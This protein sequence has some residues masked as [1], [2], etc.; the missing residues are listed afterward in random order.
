MKLLIADDQNSV[1]LFLNQMLSYEELGITEV[2]HARNGQ[3]AL[4]VIR[5]EW[6]EI[7]LL[8]IRMPVMDGLTLLEKISTM[9]FEHRVLI[10]SA[11]NEFEYA[12]KCIV[13]GVKEYLL[14]P[15]DI[16]EVKEILKKNIQELKELRL[17][18]WTAAL[19]DYLDSGKMDQEKI[20]MGFGKKGFGVVVQKSGDAELTIV[21]EQERLLLTVHADD[22]VFHFIETGSEAMWETFYERHADAQRESSVGFSQ[23]HVGREAVFQSIREGLEAVQQGFYYPGIY[24]FQENI[25]NSYP[26]KETEQLSAQLTGNYKSGD[27]QEL[28]QAVD[29]LFFIFRRKNVHPKF[30]QEFCYGMLIRL[31]ENFMEQVKNLK[32]S[33]LTEEF[34][35]ADASSLKNT[36]LRLMLSMR[37]EISPEEVRT[38]EDVIRRIRH[39]VDANYEKDLSLTTLAKHYFVSKYQISRLFKKEFGINFSDYV[40]KVRMEA[41]C[42][43]LLDS[44][45]KLDEI[46][47]KTGFEDTSYFSRVF[48]KY[49]EITP[50]EYR[51]REGR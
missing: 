25:W 22:M 35:F 48:S 41:A 15:I 23:Y 47:R 17:H 33:A 2:F 39:Y 24:L 28:K 20:P 51:K 7:L 12:R 36:F 40:L 18:K 10:L 30:V 45:D 16:K 6:P 37:L 38:D 32:G 9:E 13:Y 31:D 11:Y 49:F 42:M 1:H 50:G 14:K 3:E 43:M 19:K 44:S 29:R 8:D 46:A 5:Q 26:A 21:L 4:E 27:V 34:F